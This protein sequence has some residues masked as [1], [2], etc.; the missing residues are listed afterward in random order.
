MTRNFR[1]Q[2]AALI[3]AMLTVTLVATFAAA[4]LWQQWLGVEIESAERQRVQLNWVLNGALDWA[5][6]ILKE[7]ARTSQVDHLSEPWA[8]PLQ[9]ARLSSFLAVDKDN[10]DDAMDAFLSGQILDEQARLNVNNLVDNGERQNVTIKAFE[11]LFNLLKIPEFQLEM[12]VNNLI[13]AQAAGVL[14]NAPVSGEKA[15]APLLPLRV[16]QLV[17]LG[18]TPATVQRIAP[19]VTLL[20]G[21][22]VVN[23]NTAQPEVLYAVLPGIELGVARRMEVQ[24]ADAHYATV[25]DAFRAAGLRTEQVDISQVGVASRFFSV[26]G[27]LRIGNMIVQEHSLVERQGTLVKVLWREREVA[28]VEA[29]GAG[30][31]LQ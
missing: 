14:T 1:Q 7:D 15:I 3:T 26:R 9:E 18:L 31:T 23:L 24:R 17:W 27:R 6:L 21:R 12:L 13:K 28:D 30:A 5:R 11:R 2:G 22:N 4:A 8:L 25:G 29:G 19:Y 10:T 20:P 16:S